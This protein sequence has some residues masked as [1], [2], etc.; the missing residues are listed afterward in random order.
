MVLGGCGAGSLV[1]LGEAAPVAP[2]FDPPHIVPGIEFAGRNDNPTLTGDL[3]EIYFTSARDDDNGDVWTAQ[4]ASASAPFDP[5]QRVAGVNDPL[6]FES[7]SAVA[8]DGLTLW[9]GSNRG[10]VEGDLDVW[11]TTR[12]ARSA[13]WSA[14]TKVDVLNS[15]AR[16]IPR[17]PGLTGLVMP[18]AS[19]RDSGDVY[20]TFLATRAGADAPFDAPVLISELVFPG[21]AT[22]DGFLTEDG[23]S[24]FYSSSV[25]E[26]LSDM[27]VARRR[28]T[29]DPFEVI[30]PLADLNTAA[31]ERDPWLSPDGTRFFFVSDRAGTLAIYETTVRLP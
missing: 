1:T 12:T 7:S 14:P 18:F 10:N 28:T 9:F 15:T 21:R 4:R 23:L 30:Q 27:Y 6:T 11:V 31:D 2:R 5:P 25:P 13:L 24:L 17:P 8:L 19:T 16:D 22:V 20:R 26:G 29:A 3:M